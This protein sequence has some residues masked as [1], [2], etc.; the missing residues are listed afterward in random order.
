MCYIEITLD[1]LD[2]DERIMFE[3]FDLKN[4]TINIANRD[5]IAER[6]YNTT[7]AANNSAG[8]AISYSVIST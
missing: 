5:L 1:G 2:T 7:F 8:S 6:Q 4:D 3:Y